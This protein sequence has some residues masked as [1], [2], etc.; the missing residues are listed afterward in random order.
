MAKTTLSRRTML[1]GILGGAGISLALPLFEAMLNT[2]GTAHADGSSLPRRLGLFYW[3]NGT[4]LT[5]WTP[6]GTGYD[7]VP[8]SILQPLADA[9][10]KHKVS[11]VSGLNMK[12]GGAGHHTGRALMLSGTYDPELG[13][14]G[15]PTGRT[16]D[17]IAADQLQGPTPYRSLELGISRRGFEN[18]QS[19]S[20]MAW[21]DPQSPLP[22][23]H[24][25]VAL[26][27]R[28]FSGGVEGSGP[29]ALVDARRSVLDVVKQDTV[30]LQARLGASDRMRLEAHLDGVRDLENLLDFDL[31]G[32]AV[33]EIPEEPADDAGMELLEQRNAVMAKLLAMALA[34]DLTRVFTYKYTGMQTDTY[35]WPVDAPDGLH[36][37]THDDGQQEHVRDCIEFMMKELGVL[38]GELDAIPEGT[39]TLLDQCGIY[40]TSDLA[41]GRTHSGNDMPI[42][43]AGSAGGNLNTNY[44]H[45]ADGESTSMAPL[46]VMRACGVDVQGFGAGDAYTESTLTALEP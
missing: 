4:I 34:C 42:L 6:D 44:H 9:G 13:D 40:C 25:P 33:P 21:E 43:V 12:L 10:V 3:G 27:N 39:G 30:A 2:S 28:L 1:R 29:G 14:W 7:W 31:S 45:R 35:F 38:L 24:S 22:A 5:H 18:S 19:Y 20:A 41:E 37:M 15:R 11:V 16:F 26:W 17:Q 36:G 8:K 23:E 46:T 32:C